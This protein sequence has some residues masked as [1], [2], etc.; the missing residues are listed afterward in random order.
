MVTASDVIFALQ[1]VNDPHVPISIERM[2]MLHA[3]DVD[4]DGQVTIHL[5]MPC[6]SCPGVA[7]LESAIREKVSKL[8]GVSKVAIDFGWARPWSIDLLASDA[9]ATLKEHGILY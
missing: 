8:S 3:V 9:R 2:G 5:S 4:Q 1:G 6:L 7:V